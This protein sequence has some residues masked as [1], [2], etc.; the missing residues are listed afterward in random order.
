MNYGIPKQDGSG[1]GARMNFNRGGC[2]GPGAFGNMTRAPNR[3][4][5]SAMPPINNPVEVSYQRTT[6]KWWHGVLLGVAAITA[7]VIAR[8]V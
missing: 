4:F 8:K 1:R 2:C 5:S 7:I 6:F 3:A